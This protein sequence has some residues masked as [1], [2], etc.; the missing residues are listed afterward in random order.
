[1][2][3]GVDKST[4]WLA[5]WAMTTMGFS[6][7]L[8]LRRTKGERSRKASSETAKNRNRAR[9]ILTEEGREELR[10]GKK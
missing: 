6:R 7:V 2:N 5:S 8:T 4:D 9:I 1:M 3:R 10:R